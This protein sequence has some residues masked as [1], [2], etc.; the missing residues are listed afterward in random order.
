MSTN[1]VADAVAHAESGAWQHEPAGPLGGRL[2]DPQTDSFDD[3]FDAPWGDPQDE[4]GAPASRAVN[5]PAPVWPSV[6]GCPLCETDGGLLIAHLGHCRVIRP[7]E[8]GF[9]ALYRVVSTA[10]VPEWTD[11]PEADQM[12]LLRVVNT[13]ERALRDTLHPSKINLA[14]LGNVVPHLHWHVIA[15]F[16]WDS[17]FPAPIWGQAQRVVE[18]GQL[19]VLEHLM[20]RVDQ[21]IRQRLLPW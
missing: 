3:P 9:P 5:P 14:T 17:H 19:A 8:P 16:D 1:W 7:N 10:H 21:L 15:R 20:P 4:A 11:L 12:A 6:L 13:V 18:A 2:Y